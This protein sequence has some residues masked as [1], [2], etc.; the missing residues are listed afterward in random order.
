MITDIHSHILPAMDDGAKNTEISLEML[1]MQVEQGVDNLVL[2]PHCYRDREKPERFLARRAQ[3]FG[4]LTDAIGERDA[5]A[6]R[7]LLGAEVAWAPHLAD[8]DELPELCIQGT[9]N[10]LLEMPFV[11]WNQSMIDQI[12]DMMGRRGVTPVFAHLE[13]YTKHQKPEYIR[14]I[15]SLGTPIQISSAPLLHL[16]GRRPLVKML[17]DHT[18]HLL[19]S[20]CHNL[21]SRPP[22]LRAGLDTVRKLLGDSEAERLMAAA[23]RL[24]QPE[25]DREG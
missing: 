8:W 14:E 20:D 2:T 9:R 17:R 6:P 12:Y 13:R 10:L 3:A 21:D 19:A 18:A 11:P 23:D 15:I 5:P 24:I 16:L 7:L 25:E 22:N 1:R 4:R